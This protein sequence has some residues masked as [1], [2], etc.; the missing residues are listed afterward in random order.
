MSV[1]PFLTVSRKLSR[2]PALAEFLSAPVLYVGGNDPLPPAAGAVLAWGRKPSATKAEALATRLALPLWRLEDGFIHS[3][4]QGVLGAASCSLVVDQQGIY[5]DATAP[6]DLET[7]LATDPA[8][9]L[10]DPALLAHADDLIRQMTCQQISKYN[11]A[12]PG[13][14]AVQLPVGKKVLLVDQTAGDM[15]LQYG[16]VDATLPARMLEAALQEHPDA[17]I[18]IKTHPDVIAGKKKGCLP[19]VADNPRVQVISASVNPLVLLQEVGHVYVLTSQMGFEALLLG[20][21]V[22][23]F[24]MPFYAG[25]GL[26]DDRADRAFPV[27]QRRHRTRTLVEVFAAAY[28]LY[29]RY[30][31]PDTGQRCGLGAIVGY[32]ATQQRLFRENAGT[33]FCFGFTFWKRN[34]IRR[35]LHAPGNRLVFVWK[36]QS[37]LSRGFDDDCHIVAWGERAMQEAVALSA[38]SGVPVWR[39]ED[40]FIRSVGLGS[41]YTPPLSL[42][43]DKRGIYYDPNQPSDLEYLLQTADFPPELC[44]RASTLR[45]ALLQNRISKYNLGVEPVRERIGTSVGQRIILVPGQVEDDAS[46][47][48]G[49]R[50]IASNTALLEAVRLARPEAYIIYKPHPDVVSG[51]RRGKVAADVLARCCDVVLED[52]SLP[53]CLD[54]ADE[55]HTMTSLVGFEGLLRGKQVACYGLPFYAGW[56]LTADRHALARR[57]RRVTLDELVAATLILYPRYMNWQTGAFTTPEHA[58]ETLRQ[59]IGAQG[60]NK[61][62][63]VNWLYR[64]WRKVL[65]VYHGVFNFRY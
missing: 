28:L 40:G 36:K 4:G 10:S 5:Y 26:T 13:L 47:R 23:C 25:W 18:L 33:L 29:S 37:A 46:I 58:V 7:L 65:H 17:H 16:L 64:Q 34:Y 55:V 61:K 44:N 15:S 3:L 51:N 41:D 57:S 8:Q 53:D 54:I 11:N 56:G 62:N 27:F 31:H 35:F 6:S 19:L 12:P 1:T 39:V 30:V 52:A 43:L 63:K 9:Q 24:G 2:H 21:P 49:C 45:N 42:V 20:K 22:T 59:Q 50:D 32:M 38:A 60:G 14:G 48:K